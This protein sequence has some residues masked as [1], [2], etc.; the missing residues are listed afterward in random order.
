MSTDPHWFAGAARMTALPDDVPPVDDLRGFIQGSFVHTAWAAAYGVDKVHD[1]RQARSAAEMIDAIRRVDARPLLEPREPEQRAG[2]VCRHFTTLAVALLRRE[3]VAARARCGFATYFEAGK[4]IDHWIVEAYDGH[5]WVQR[6][7]QLDELQLRSV[8]ATFD[9]DDLP[10]GAFLNGAHAWQLVSSGRVD[11]DTFGIFDLHGTWF[12]HGNLVRDLAALN[13]V[14]MLPWDVWGCMA[15]MGAT[16]DDVRYAKDLA[17]V[18]A[19]T[20]SPRCAAR[21]TTTA[22]ACRAVS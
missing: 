15:T 6:D 22:C 13:K 10:S 8:A 2:V 4:Y 16:P 11:P 3:G 21:T 12:A 17:E 7:F 14:E 18:V 20:T 5:R 9:P 1:E 19:A